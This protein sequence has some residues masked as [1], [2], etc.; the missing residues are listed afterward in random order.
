MLR[1]SQT[2]RALR[3]KDNRKTQGP[4]T[5]DQVE[6]WMIPL[7]ERRRRPDDGRYQP[8]IEEE[9]GPVTI[10]IFPQKKEDSERGVVIIPLG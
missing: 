7:I 3:G 8:E 9:R 6:P 10:P 4:S 1:F 5:D 2:S